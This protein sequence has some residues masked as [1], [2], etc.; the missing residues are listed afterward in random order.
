MRIQKILISLLLIIIIPGIS[1]A[2][3]PTGYI[4]LFA[5]DY[6]GSWCIN[7]VGFYQAS[8]W[9]WCLPGQDGMVCAEFDISYPYNVIEAGINYNPAILPLIIQPPDGWSLCFSECRTDWVWMFNQIIFVTTVDKTMLEI[10]PMPDV[11]V[12]QFANCLPG[13]PVEPCIKLTNLYINYE[14]DE[15]ECST[16]GVEASSWGAIKSLFR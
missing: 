7:G 12:Y 8:M 2:Q 1:T 15:S 4:G 13:Y 14:P 6:R 16:T 3:A 9:V 11:G 5:D 10:V